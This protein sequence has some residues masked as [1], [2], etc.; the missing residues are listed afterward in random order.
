MF[1][2]PATLEKDPKTGAVLV[3]FHDIPFC[4]SVGDDENDALLNAVNALIT[5]F[6]LFEKRCEPIPSPSVA[7]LGQPVVW[8]P[9]LVASKALLYNAM[10]ASGKRKTDLAHSLNVPPPLVDRLISMRHKSRIDQIETAMATFGKRLT[11]DAVA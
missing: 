10:L 6:E 11:V 4:H 9:V 5:A 3:G 8:L 7:A 2:Y 1:C